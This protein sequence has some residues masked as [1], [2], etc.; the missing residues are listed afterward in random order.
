MDHDQFNSLA[1]QLRSESHTLLAAGVVICGGAI[2][3]GVDILQ[4]DTVPRALEIWIAISTPLLILCLLLCV[5]AQFLIVRRDYVLLELIR[6]N[7]EVPDGT[8]G[9][10]WWIWLCGALA[11]LSFSLGLICAAIGLV[12]WAARWQI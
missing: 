1:A 7:K 8:P 11:L 10:D 3:L 4:S 6:A 12:Q 9:K 2:A 5:F